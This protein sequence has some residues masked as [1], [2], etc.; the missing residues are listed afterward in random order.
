MDFTTMPADVKFS[1]AQ[2]NCVGAIRIAH[3][4]GVLFKRVG[5]DTRLE[6]GLVLRDGLQSFPWGH[7]LA[8]GIGLADL[9]FGVDA[10]DGEV[11]RAAEVE[12][13]VE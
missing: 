13:R 6:E 3:C 8:V 10:V 7:D 12:L 4:G 9:A 5:S 11:T 1:E 2:F